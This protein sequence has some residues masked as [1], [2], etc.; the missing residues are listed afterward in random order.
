MEKTFEAEIAQ[1]V[2][3]SKERV[4]LARLK[5]EEK[6]HDDRMEIK[7]RKLDLN[8]LKMSQEYDIKKRKS[9][10]EI[11]ASHAQLIS[12]LR[13]LGLPNADIVDYMRKAESA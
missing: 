6:E 2:M 10:A 4:A 12:E 11:L 7:K 9:T 3:E 13:A 1:Q 8:E 5:L